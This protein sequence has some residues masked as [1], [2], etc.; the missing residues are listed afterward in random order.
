[1]NGV[2]LEKERAIGIRRI[3]QNIGEIA[4]TDKA[5][6]VAEEKR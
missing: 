6:Y 4:G 5:W 3:F 1:M 2:I